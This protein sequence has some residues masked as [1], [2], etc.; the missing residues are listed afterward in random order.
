MIEAEGNLNPHKPLVFLYSQCS[1]SRGDIVLQLAGFGAGGPGV[2]V[3]GSRAVWGRI[4]SGCGFFSF[5]LRCWVFDMFSQFAG[6]FGFGS[7]RVSGDSLCDA[8]CSS[9]SE[10][11]AVSTRDSNSESPT[12]IGGRFCIRVG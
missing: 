5:H 2:C 12:C 10:A 8:G 1:L 4:I 11:A 9:A 3:V 7:L 6:L